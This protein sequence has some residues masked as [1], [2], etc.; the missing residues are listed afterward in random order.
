[1]DEGPKQEFAKNLLV[2][3]ALV[4]GS[5]LGS[6]LG[7][8]VFGIRP[9]YGDIFGFGMAAGLFIHLESLRRHPGKV[10]DTSRTLLVAVLTA[11]ASF[12]IAIIF[13]FV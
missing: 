9:L 5:A 11:A 2:P 8:L 7:S 12:L 10:Y 3:L 4:I 1:M 6:K 13:R